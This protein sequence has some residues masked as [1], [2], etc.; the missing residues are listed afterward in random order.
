MIAIISVHNLNSQ[1]NIQRWLTTTIISQFIKMA[2]NLEPH[3]EQQSSS[4]LEE[5]IRK[6]RTLERSD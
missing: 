6:S 1:M 3:L 5:N 4:D 2:D